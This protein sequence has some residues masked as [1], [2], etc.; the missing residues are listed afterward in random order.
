MRI[1]VQ[2]TA[3]QFLGPHPSREGLAGMVY[4]KEDQSILSVSLVAHCARKEKA[5]TGLKQ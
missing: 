3:W 2:E 4:I 5:L 1:I